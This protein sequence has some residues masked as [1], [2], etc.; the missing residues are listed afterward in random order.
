MTSCPSSPLQLLPPVQGSGKRRSDS[1]V[2]STTSVHLSFEVCLLENI[3]E[4]VVIV[5]EHQTSLQA[6]LGTNSASSF[7]EDLNKWR[8]I[9]QTIEAVLKV[10][11]SV[12]DLWY[13]LQEVSIQVHSSYVLYHST[14]DV[15]CFM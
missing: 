14:N 6:L 7:M 8:K 11:K 5:N 4:V 3:D 12:Q 10:W 2:L 15:V 13:L 9:L 1:V